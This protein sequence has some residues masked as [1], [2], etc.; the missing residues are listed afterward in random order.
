MKKA[1]IFLLVAV[2]V[3]A[4]TACGAPAEPGE[5]TP[6][7]VPPAVDTPDVEP[8]VEGPAAPPEETPDEMPGVTPEVDGPAAPPEETPDM[9]PEVD[10]P[11][12]E[13]EEPPVAD[14]PV[15]PPAAGGTVGETLRGEF[16]NIM[17]SGSAAGAEA[18]AN[19]VLGCELLANSEIALM[20]MPIEGGFLSGFDNVEITGFSEGAMFAPMIGSIPF[21]GYV[22][23]LDDGADVASFAQTLED[24]ANLRWN[25]CVTADEM[26]VETYGNT[27]F[28]LMCPASLQG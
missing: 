15:A 20:A 10:V 26:V 12:I 16:V 23:V 8:D 28:F 27:V 17:T 4:M 25:I 22:F 11:A 2:M 3:F 9:A 21:V 18:V 14:Q 13:P 24:N 7:P 1:V 19:A 5:P 6:A